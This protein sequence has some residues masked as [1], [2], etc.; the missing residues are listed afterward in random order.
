VRK[1][2]APPKRW[3]NHTAGKIVVNERMAY[4]FQYFPCLPFKLGSA[5]T[6]ET[7]AC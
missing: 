5:G 1:L 2:A 7:E 6:R 3:R 4:Q